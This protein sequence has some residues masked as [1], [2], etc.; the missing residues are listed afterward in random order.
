M[1]ETIASLTHELIVFILKSKI[2]SECDLLDVGFNQDP[3]C[4]SDSISC[5]NFTAFFNFISFFVKVILESSAFR[6][7]YGLIVILCVCNSLRRPLW[8]ARLFTFS[9]QRPRSC[10]HTHTHT[11]THRRSN[12][13]YSVLDW[14]ETG[15]YDLTVFTCPKWATVRCSSKCHGWLAW[16]SWGWGWYVTHWGFSGVDRL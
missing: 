3:L 11:H 16:T 10:T 7:F 13:S 14:P 4:S 12:N 6:Y 5:L 2:I 1:F 15:P 9:G 8:V